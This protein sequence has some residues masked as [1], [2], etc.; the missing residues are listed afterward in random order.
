MRHWD[1]PGRLLLAATQTVP[2]RSPGSII[3][4]AHPNFTEVFSC[5]TARSQL[6]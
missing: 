2:Y 6:G 3:A 5:G 1:S 4:S